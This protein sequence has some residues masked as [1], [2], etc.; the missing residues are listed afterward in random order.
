MKTTTSE[1]QKHEIK[2]RKTRTIKNEHRAIVTS[3]YRKL[4][5]QAKQIGKPNFEQSKIEYHKFT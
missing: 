4:I 1:N 2:H 3:N 5:Q